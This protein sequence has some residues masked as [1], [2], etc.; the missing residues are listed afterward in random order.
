MEN[1]FPHLIVN[2]TDNINTEPCYLIKC[3]FNSV[4]IG[5]L[6]LV[7][8]LSWAEFSRI[9]FN[10]IKENCN[11]L[12]ISFYYSVLLTILAVAICFLLMYHFPSTIW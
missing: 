4:L 5:T 8:A 7:V 6:I 10:R 2:N 11:E 12:T 1:P 9:I 3:S